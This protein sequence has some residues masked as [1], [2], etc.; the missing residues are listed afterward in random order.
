MRVKYDREMLKTAIILVLLFL[1]AVSIIRE[2]FVSRFLL[3][4]TTDIT[5]GG[6]IKRQFDLSTNLTYIEHLEKNDTRE[7]LSS[8]YEAAMD[9]IQCV[10]ED[11]SQ[12]IAPEARE[13]FNAKYEAFMAR[14]CE[15]NFYSACLSYGGF[16]SQRDDFDLASKAY[17]K[18]A[19]NGNQAA[20]SRLYYLYSNQ[21]W[22]G[23]S[24][25]KSEYWLGR[26]T[27]EQPN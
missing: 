19:N 13:E 12:C 4:V 20:A 8:L 11:V 25:E 10:D 18:A 1:L 27:T 21:H 26:L 9:N 7:I 22:D 23:H 14:E 5:E 3:D 16:L 2:V 24:D 17:V 6:H 15:N